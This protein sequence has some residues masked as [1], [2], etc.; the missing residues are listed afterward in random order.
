[1]ATDDFKVWA[2]VN[3]ATPGTYAE[4]QTAPVRMD[5]NRA[6]YV[7]SVDNYTRANAG[8]YFTLTTT[9]ATGIAGHA[10]PTTLDDTKPYVWLKNGYTDGRRVHLDY[11]RTWVTAAGTNGTNLRFGIKIDTGA[12]RRTSAGTAMTANQVGLVSSQTSATA[13]VTAYQGAVVAAAATSSARLVSHGLLRTVINVVGDQYLFTFG[14]GQQLGAGMITE[15][16][17][18][19]QIH[20]ACPPIVLGYTDQFLFHFFSGSQSAA[21]SHEVEIGFW[22]V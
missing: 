22:V 3:R 4:N 21:S 12:D 10:A 1:M 8:Q 18:Q 2:E 13:S 6:L 15:G 19:A 9:P 7:H 20:M 5:Q 16:T 14:K 17:A 11:M